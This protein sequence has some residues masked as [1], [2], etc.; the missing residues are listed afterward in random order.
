MTSPD[1]GVAIHEPT[2]EQAFDG[3]ELL[4]LVTAQVCVHSA[5]TGAR[6]AAPLPFA[7]TSP[8]P[9][10]VYSVPMRFGQLL[11]SCRDEASI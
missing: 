2:Q 6:L 8:S 7:V 11:L 3:R 9:R 5:M 4:R 10:T 1:R